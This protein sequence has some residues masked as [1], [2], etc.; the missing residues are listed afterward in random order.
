M[1][2]EQARQALQAFVTQHVPLVAA[3]GIEV[4][5]YDAQSLVL[6]APLDKNINDKGTAFGGSLYNLCVVTGWGLTWLLSQE[7]QLAGEIV[8]AKGEIEYLRPLRG[9]LI[10]TVARPEQDALCHFKA[11]YAR[12]GKAVLQQTVTIPDETGTPCVRFQGKYA[13]VAEP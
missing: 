3:A 8:V 5:H 13:L 6:S 11:G 1:N 9:R 7:L 2:S 12:R 10:A 4:D